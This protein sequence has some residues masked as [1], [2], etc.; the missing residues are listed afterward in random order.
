VELVQ[1]VVKQVN[2]LITAVG[3]RSDEAKF[4]PEI[5]T[6]APPVVAAFGN[7]AVVTAGASKLST[8]R[9]VPTVADTVTGM[10]RR[11]SLA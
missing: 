10:C 5:V 4:K 11:R 8:L 6:V 9:T 2:V 1:E 3:E 7:K